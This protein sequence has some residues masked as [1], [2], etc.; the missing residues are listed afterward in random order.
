MKL[1][2]YI[3]MIHHV[4]LLLVIQ[5]RERVSKP[6]INPGK[7]KTTGPSTA[8]SLNVFTISQRAD[9]P[10]SNIQPSRFNPKG[11]DQQQWAKSMNVLHEKPRCSLWEDVFVVDCQAALGLLVS[12]WT[13]LVWS[14]Y[15]YLFIFR[16]SRTLKKYLF[17]S[18][19]ECP[20]I[21]GASAFTNYLSAMKSL[22]PCSL[23]SNKNTL[24]QRHWNYGEK[25]TRSP[26]ENLEKKMETQGRKNSVFGN[27]DF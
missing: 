6:G 2:Q 19:S 7:K 14:K 4:W 26:H 5:A 18:S 15:K 24:P 17:H 16:M 21:L 11:P 25:T 8:S 20:E 22:F 3:A 10:T 12:H 23:K 27:D 1:L 9:Q 13:T